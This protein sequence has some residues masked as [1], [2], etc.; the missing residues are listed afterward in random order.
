MFKDILKQIFKDKFASTALIILLLMYL[1]ILMADFI[2]PYS[3]DFSDRSLSYA[4]PSTIYIIDENGKLSKPYFC[5]EVCKCELHL[6]LQYT[7]E[8]PTPLPQY[9]SLNVLRVCP[10]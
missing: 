9:L 7:L 1:C 10:M 8:I 2:A 4:P 3:K 5:I 6:V